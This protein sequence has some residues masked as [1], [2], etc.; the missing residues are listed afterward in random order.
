MVNVEYRGLRIVL[1]P[2]EVEDC[3]CALLWVLSNA[4]HTSST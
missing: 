2:A 3:R 4:A 1:A